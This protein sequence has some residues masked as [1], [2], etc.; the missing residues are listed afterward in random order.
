MVRFSLLSTTSLAAV[1]NLVNNEFRTAGRYVSEFNGS[2]LAS[3]IYFYRISV[4]DGKT[5]DMVKKMVL[6]K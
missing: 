1:A 2:R 4:D 5:F 6:V 3:G